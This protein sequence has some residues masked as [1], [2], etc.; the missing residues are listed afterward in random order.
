LRVS[1]CFRS[2][3]DGSRSDEWKELKAGRKSTGADI[4]DDFNASDM[5]R[6]MTP[7]ETENKIDTRDHRA[8]ST[9]E[10][11]GQLQEVWIQP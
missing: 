6:I 5:H 4:S 7:R 9:G 3:E 10:E 1:T 11:R 2:S 8:Q